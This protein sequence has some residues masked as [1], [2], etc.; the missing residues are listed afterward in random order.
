MNKLPA[1]IRFLV[2]SFEAIFLLSSC[3]RDEPAAT[4]IPTLAPS[5]S[6][7]PLPPTP[8]LFSEPIPTA[9]TVQPTEQASQI[10]EQEPDKIIVIDRD[11]PGE[12]ASQMEVLIQE[13]QGEY[14]LIYEQESGYQ[15]EFIIEQDGDHQ[16]IEWI[17]AAAGPFAATADGMTL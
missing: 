14:R 16:L 15:P 8:T 12:I 1:V 17:Y 9:V 13:L 6:D 5:P 7:T 11:I 10:E 2:I 3:A 4:L